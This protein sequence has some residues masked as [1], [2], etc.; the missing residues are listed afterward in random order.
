MAEKKIRVLCSLEVDDSDNGFVLQKDDPNVRIFTQ[1]GKGG[2]QPGMITA[3][4]AGTDVDFQAEGL[5]GADGWVRI[6]NTSQTETVQFGVMD[7]RGVCVHGLHGAERARD[8]PRGL[9]PDV[10]IRLDR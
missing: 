1:A 5:T 10:P 2:G 8:V 6:E 9:Y 4:A 7:R 3:A